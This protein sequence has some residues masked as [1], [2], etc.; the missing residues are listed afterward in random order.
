MVV[1]DPALP[2][3][4]AR[5]ARW[6]FSAHDVAS[7]LQETPPGEGIRLAMPWQE[8]PAHKDL[9]L[10]VRYTTDN[11]Q[12]LQADCP[13]ELE[14]S[15]QQARAREPGLLPAPAGQAAEELPATPL[16]PV[17][18]GK[19]SDADRAV[20]SGSEPPRRTEATATRPTWSPQRR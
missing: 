3:E 16:R 10:F 8:T 20:A 14:P 13:L 17:E 5:I 15:P 12:K 6:D 4:T 9:R 7:L 2:G 19:A 11:G 1:L 18:D